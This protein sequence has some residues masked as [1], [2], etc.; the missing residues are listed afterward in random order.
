[1]REQEDPCDICG[2]NEGSEVM[3]DLWVCRKCA[4]KQ[5]KKK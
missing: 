2:I 4:K 5:K 1:M 3:E